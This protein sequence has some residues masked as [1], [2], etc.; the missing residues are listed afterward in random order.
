MGQENGKRPRMI[1]HHD[2]KS[3]RSENDCRTL[4]SSVT[5]VGVAK[6]CPLSLDSTT[7]WL[8]SICWQKQQN[9]LRLCNCI[10]EPE[11]LHSNTVSTMGDK[12]IAPLSTPVTHLVGDTPCTGLQ[13][14]QVE[15]MKTLETVSR[16]AENFGNMDKLCAKHRRKFRQIVFLKTNWEPRKANHFLWF[17]DPVDI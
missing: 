10:E 6:F 3:N 2:K 5:W 15:T 1:I 16:H 8:Y 13:G 4:A 12:S 11:T 7:A 14:H 9:S 17:T